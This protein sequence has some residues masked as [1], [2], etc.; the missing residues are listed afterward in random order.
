[1]SDKDH[2]PTDALRWLVNQ[3]QGR[4]ALKHIATLG[5]VAVDV[6]DPN[7]SKM[8]YAAGRRSLAI[9]ILQQIKQADET[10]FAS[11]IGDLL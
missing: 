5:G 10:A 7:N 4:T 11:F 2:N 3:A 1:M 8:S 9:E 6:F